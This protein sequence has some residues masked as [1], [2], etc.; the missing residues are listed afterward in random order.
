MSVDMNLVI[1]LELKFPDGR[2]ASKCLSHILLEFSENSKVFMGTCLCL[3]NLGLF[4]ATSKI[5]LK[6]ISPR[7]EITFDLI[8]EELLHVGDVSDCWHFDS[9]DGFGK[10]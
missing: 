5:T 2:L 3:P 7:L 4:L 1:C 6:L 8:W 9:Q 10:H